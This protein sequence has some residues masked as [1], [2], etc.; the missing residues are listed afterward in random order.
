MIYIQR[1]GQG[2]L[3]TIDE[4]ETRKEATALVREYRLSD[5]SA[6]Y[7]LSSRPCEAWRDK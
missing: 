4:C 5:Y 1:K 2:Y 3:E 7:Y 6:E